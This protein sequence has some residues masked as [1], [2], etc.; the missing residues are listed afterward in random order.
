[1]S[2][3]A[4]ESQL[5]GTDA[6]GR[7][8]RLVDELLLWA[9]QKLLRKLGI[10][11]MNLVVLSAVP[12]K[13]VPGEAL[14]LPLQGSVL[15]PQ[16]WMS[17]RD[18]GPRAPVL[19]SLAC[20]WLGTVQTRHGKGLPLWPEALW[21]EKPHLEIFLNNHTPSCAPN[22]CSPQSG[23]DGGDWL[24]EVQ[25]WENCATRETGTLGTLPRRHQTSGEKCP[26][27]DADSL[28]RR[29]EAAG[30][31]TGCWSSQVMLPQMLL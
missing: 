4:Y 20:T 11:A 5:R 25:G 8:C 6:G 28:H 30:T 17:C 24:T 12:P 14:H 23:C 7:R 18:D 9:M 15:Q 19:W 27:H 2:V 21:A 13:R 10:F 26:G 31:D 16:G 29:S 1:M 22:T 3:F